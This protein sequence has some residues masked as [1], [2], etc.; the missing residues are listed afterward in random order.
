ME[1]WLQWACGQAVVLLLRSMSGSNKTKLAP[2]PAGW[3]PKEKNLFVAWWKDGTKLRSSA[4]GGSLSELVALSSEGD[5][6]HKAL[7]PHELERL[8]VS[9]G[10][11][12]RGD[13]DRRIVLLPE[14]HLRFEG[15]EEAELYS[16]DEAPEEEAK[17]GR[18]EAAHVAVMATL[19]LV[20]PATP[21]EA[22]AKEAA[23]KEE[24]K[25]SGG[26]SWVKWLLV[27]LGIGLLL[28]LRYNDAT[29]DVQWED[30]YAHYGVLGLREGASAAEAK[31]AFHG[32]SLQSHPDKLGDR[33]DAACKERFQ[34][35]TDAY[36]AIRDYHAGR[37]RI[38]NQPTRHQEDF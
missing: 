30:F 17:K 12:E 33:C 6:Q 21:Q 36:A 28:Y 25:K 27:A 23:A 8:S 26:R 24:K 1:E 16:D 14:G 13:G 9:V 4:Y 19:P 29:Y 18:E 10:V 7:M 5:K 15:G 32:L 11:V 3:R 22:A 2:E 38:L 34:R 37:L 20:Q 35:L 31:K